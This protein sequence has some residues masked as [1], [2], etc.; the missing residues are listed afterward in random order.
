MGDGNGRRLW[1]LCV[2]DPSTGCATRPVGVV[3]VDG[4]DRWLSWLPHEPGAALWT[5]RV[6]P[7]A[8]VAAV[9]VERWARL[10]DGIVLGLVAIDDSPAAV[11]LAGAVEA[12]ADIAL[13]V[14]VTRRRAG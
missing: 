11:D 14:A 3:G 1:W 5:Q 7:V 10:A 9:R 13:A 12:A 4:T 2:Y 8:D 6:G